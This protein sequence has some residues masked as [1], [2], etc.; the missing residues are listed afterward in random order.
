MSEDVATAELVASARTF[1]AYGAEAFGYVEDREASIAV[2]PN[3]LITARDYV[4]GPMRFTGAVYDGQNELVRS[5]LGFSEG[6]FTP[7]DPD[8]IAPERRD[9]AQPVRRAVYGGTLYSILGHFL[10]ETVARLW[11]GVDFAPRYRIGRG[12]LPVVFHPW[13]GQELSALLRNPLYRQ[14]LAALGIRPGDIVLATV[15]LKVETLYYPSPLSVYH[16]TLHPMMGIVLD[17]LVAQLQARRSALARLISRKPPRTRIFL[18]RSRWAVHRRVSNE[19]A[20][21]ALFRAQGFT[22]VHPQKLAPGELVELLQDAEIV[23]ST[24]G[25]QAHLVAFCRPGTRTVLVDTR[26]VPTQFAIEKLRQLRGF[27]I[28]VYTNGLW[29]AETGAIEVSATL[30][31][32]IAAV[33]APCFD[34]AG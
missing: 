19:P 33:L 4:D 28:P 31:R 5:S 13:P 8:R 2:V 27:H 24:D 17:H 1:T 21:E 9:G 16:V 34:A 12:S 11:H 20:L 14:I 25:S 32:L 22:I 6:D 26:P 7:L 29:N 23:A 15:D 3:A 18:S 10:F 30:E